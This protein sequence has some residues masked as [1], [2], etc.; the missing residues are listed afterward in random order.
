LSKDM[1]MTVPATTLTNINNNGRTWAYLVVMMAWGVAIVGG[2][3]LIGF[4]VYRVFGELPI[5]LLGS[6]V[7]S[8]IFIP[9]LYERAKAD[10]RLFM[11]IDGPGRL[12]EYRIGARVPLQISGRGVDFWSKSGT[13]RTLLTAFDIETLEGDGS[14]MAEFNQFE[15]VRDL[16]TIDVLSSEL[17]K[18]LKETRIT[19]QTVGV[20]VEKKAAE[21]VDW[22]LQMI[23]GAIIPTE[24]SEAFGIEEESKELQV[25]EM[26]DDLVEGDFE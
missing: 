22:S 2:L 13:S 8:F 3:A 9:F 24:I 6:I 7:G 17:Q 20:E 4:F 11:V 1:T 19:K 26:L 12:T 10:A 16:N 21:V 23:Y 18:H 25:D 15:Q 14:A 5:W